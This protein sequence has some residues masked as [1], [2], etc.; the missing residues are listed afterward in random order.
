[1]SDKQNNAKRWKS[2]ILFSVVVGLI[3][4]FFS[5]VSD[6]SPYFGE[7][8]NVSATET[9]MSYLASMINSLPI[10]FIIAMIVG[11]LYGRNLKEGILFGA[12]YTTIAIT[13]YFI[14]GSIY[15]K[16][17]IALS[18]KEIITVFI[19]W[20]GA[21][22]IGGCIGGAAGFLVKKTPYVL[23]VLPLGLTLQL[24]L[25]GLRSWSN[26]VGIAQNLTFCMMIVVSLLLF[27]SKRK[28]HSTYDVQK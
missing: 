16:T 25:H 17:T 2:F 5:V 20:Y 14:L 23:L 3:V 7:G 26:V 15:E 1:M 22:I 28:Y 4:G 12:I 11:Y 8:S 13:F 6:H 27:V 24:Y 21:S 19:T 9:I 18:S 10:W